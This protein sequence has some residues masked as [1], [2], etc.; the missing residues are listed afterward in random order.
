M[1]SMS[2]V[3]EDED[4]ESEWEKS[5]SRKWGGKKDNRKQ[6]LEE[7]NEGRYDRKKI[8]MEVFKINLKF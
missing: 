5:T 1:E 3:S 7:Q 4:M 8:M 6:A 2:G